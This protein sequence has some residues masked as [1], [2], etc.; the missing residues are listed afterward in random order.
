MNT[1]KNQFKPKLI[2]FNMI[3]IPTKNDI[4]D[5]A[6]YS[7]D[8]SNKRGEVFTP[9]PLIEQMVSA[10]PN[11]SFSNPTKTYLDPCA[12]MGNFPL[13]VMQRLMKGL[14]SRILNKEN[15][16]RHIMENQ[17]FMCEL[18]RGNCDIINR[19]F[20]PTGDIKLNILWGDALTSDVTQYFATPWEFRGKLHPTISYY[21]N[22]NSIVLGGEDHFNP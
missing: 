20:N 5:I 12:G 1:K 2:K 11:K 7:K 3:K 4:I 17:I 14:K 6:V 15:R 22:E 19:L 10:L 18:D 8:N 9:F 16:Y 13:V 21:R